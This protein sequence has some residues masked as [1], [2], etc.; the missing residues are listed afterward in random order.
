MR[1]RY[2]TAARRQ[3][4]MAAALVHLLQHLPRLTVAAECVDCGRPPRQHPLTLYLPKDAS[5]G[6]AIRAI[7]DEQTRLVRQLCQSRSGVGGETKARTPAEDP[8]A[9]YILKVCCSQVR[10]SAPSL[11]RRDL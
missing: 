11:T 2:L 9:R 6:D 7:L 8:A 5:V 3:P 10:L 1:S 4:K